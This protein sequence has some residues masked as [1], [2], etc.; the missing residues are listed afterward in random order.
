MA[1]AKPAGRPKLDKI[2]ILDLTN[3]HMDWDGQP[4]IRDKLRSGSELISPKGGEDIPSCT[5]FAQVLQP[6]VTRMSLTESRPVPAIEGLRV[7]IE[8]VYYK[9]K[10]GGNPE[11]VPDVVGMAWRIRK[12]LGFIKMKV[13]RRE[14]SHVPLLHRN[15]YCIIFWFD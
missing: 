1:A 10:R 14:V 12:L 8:A 5:G 15:Y 11:D 4:E 2:E 13:R 7:E 3:V 9:N 6:L